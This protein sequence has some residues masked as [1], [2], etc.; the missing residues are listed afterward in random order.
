M[1]AE[2]EIAR[3]CTGVV[4]AER[5]Q[6]PHRLAVEAEP[7]GETEAA[8]VDVAEP[9][10]PQAALGERGADRPR[11]RHRVTRKAERARQDARAAARQKAERHS[12]V[13]TV[14]RLV[15]GAVAGEDED[16]VDVPRNG[17][18]KLGRMARALRERRLHLH[19]LTQN[20]LD[21][22]IRSPVTWV[23]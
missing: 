14:Q 21:G 18:C 16:R 15:V 23:E 12:S 5:V 10:S 1:R 8:A 7:G 9:D 2:R 4:A 22:P 6:P 3:P 11:R 20:A 17:G 19:P 13:R